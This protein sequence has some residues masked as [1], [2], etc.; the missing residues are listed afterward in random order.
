MLIHEL[1]AR[2]AAETPSKTAVKDFRGEMGYGELWAHSASVSRALSGIG[3]KPGKAV[4]VY[5]PYA[6]EIVLGAVSA[7]RAGCVYLPFDEDYPEERLHYMLNQSGA[8]AV[9]TVRELWSRKPLQFPEG[10]VIFLE[11]LPA[12]D[13]PSG[14]IPRTEN[15]P[16]LL[17]YTSGTTGRPKGVLHRH[18][19]LA[20]LLD[21]MDEREGAAVDENAHG[22]IATGPTFIATQVF[23][24]GTLSRGGTVFIAPDAARKDLGFLD[25][26]IRECGITHLFLPSGLGA[27]LAEDYDIR[28]VYLLVGGEKLRTFRPHAP[29][30]CLFLGY[31]CTETGAVMAGKVF[32]NEERMSV[33][34]PAAGTEARIVDETLRPLPAG[35]TGEL[36]IS[37]PF[38][39]REYYRLP[40]LSAEKWITLD[41]AL[42]FRTG[43]RARCTAEENFEILG[44]TDNMVKLRGFRIETGEVEV[45]AVSAA[46]RIGRGDVGEF[47]VVLRNVGGTDHLVCYYESDRDL[48]SAAMKA[49]LARYLAEYM[50]PDIWVRMGAMPRNANGK[51]IRA[52]LPQPERTRG[53]AS[54]RALDSEVLARLVYTLEDLLDPGVSV[55][56]DDR[57]TD[58]GGTSLTAMKYTSL[59]REQGIK[60]SSSQVLQLNVLRKIAEAAE[61]AYEQLWSPEEYAEIR[62]DFASRGEHIRKVLPI[63]PEQDEMLFKQI[64]YPDRFCFMETVFL[65]VDSPVAEKDLRE[66]LD[67]VSRENEP[68]RSAIVYHHVATIQQ[69]ITDRKIPLEVVDAER[70]GGPE[71]RE[72][73]TRLLDTPMD[74]QRDSLMRVIF[75]RAA[76]RYLLCIVTH[77]IAF[78]LDRRNAYV[79]RLMRELES[80]YPD[81]VSIA[82]WR[83]LLEEN[84]SSAPAESLRAGRRSPG[85]KIQRKAPP[86]VCVY[87]ENTGPKL[88][89]VHTANTGSAAYYRL[90]AR[91]G[92]RVSFSVIEPFN[93]YHMKEACYGIPRIATRYIEI[94]KRHQPEGP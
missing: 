37:S 35:E 23:L 64:L 57:F 49:E 22:G 41:G 71:M 91:I 51:V 42:W 89:F 60:V 94:L 8:A 82:G 17:L 67:I 48:D 52:D 14:A 26:F 32:G 31:G 15:D 78:S 38:M 11:D 29:G 77:G 59:L 45:Q 85:A 93:L 27:V 16:A 47:A 86:E 13:D 72:M 68:L 69:V 43:D 30:N 21:F 81:D 25:R 3:A 65:Q 44:R 19:L 56:P 74:L 50:V 18:R 20:N 39:S 63:T 12:A 76:G 46:A 33:G 34:R 53:H 36:L 9:L 80:R 73:K 28:G 83:A 75:L 61:V 2:F 92:S 7:W 70:F 62:Q 54:W 87:S 10:K 58:L 4:A 5:V 79:A 84:A 90:A 88:V 66:A 40:E 55:S 1:I 24:F 6:K